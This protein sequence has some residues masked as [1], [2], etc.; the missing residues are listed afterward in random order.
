MDNPRAIRP[1]CQRLDRTTLHPTRW[2][3]FCTTCRVEIS[4]RQPGPLPDIRSGETDIHFRM[5]IP[6]PFQT[7]YH[8]AI[9]CE[10]DGEIYVAISSSGD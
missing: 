6:L 10:R 8:L 5:T 7:Q 3:P 1:Q 2:L 4:D 9:R